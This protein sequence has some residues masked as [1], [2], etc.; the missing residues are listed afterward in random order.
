MLLDILTGLN[1]FADLMEP[2]MGR[3]RA[4]FYRAQTG[5]GWVGSVRRPMALSIEFDEQRDWKMLDARWKNGFPQSKLEF[6]GA[7]FVASNPSWGI[8]K[9][10]G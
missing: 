4:N 2:S 3:S 5:G 7:A 6:S 9:E 8:K 10:P 1:S